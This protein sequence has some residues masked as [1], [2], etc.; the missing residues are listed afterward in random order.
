MRTSLIPEAY[1][2]FPVKE[3][4][5]LSAMQWS[6]DCDA[7]EEA[8][9]RT[10]CFVEELQE[11]FHGAFAHGSVPHFT[12]LMYLVRAFKFGGSNPAF[13]R[14]KRVY[15]ECSTAA[16]AGRN[17]G[18]L[19][20]HLCSGFA[21]M[22][23]PPSI[24]ELIETL[25]ARRRTGLRQRTDLKIDV[26]LPLSEAGPKLAAQIASLSDEQ[27]RHWF[28]F[29]RPS[30][31]PDERIAE[32]LE[33][34]PLRVLKLIA[35]ARTSPRLVGAASLIPALD[36]GLTIPPRKRSPDAVPQGGYSDVT[37]R[38][39]P[40]RLLPSQFA[41]DPDEFVRRFAEHELLYFQRE[42]P[43]E[44]QKPERVL[45]F[46]QG[47]RTWGRV[48][49]ALAGAVLSL[50][51]FDAR[52]IGDV[53]LHATSQ[54]EPLELRTAKIGALRDVLE[55]SDFTETPEETFRQALEESHSTN[56][57]SPPPAVVAARQ[58]TISPTGG[59]VK[60]SPPRDV[61]VLTHPRNVPSLLEAAESRRPG[62]RIFPFAVEE[63]GSA[64]IGELREEG[65]VW[66]RAFRLDLRAA[67]EARIEEETLPTAARPFIPWIPWTGDVEPIGF[68][69]RPGIVA[70]VDVMGFTAEGDWLVTASKN[71]LLHAIACDGSSVEV[72]PRGFKDGK[73]LPRVRTIQ[74]V[75]NGVVID[76]ASTDGEDEVLSVIHYDMVS[77]TVRFHSMTVGSKSPVC[78]AQ[79][80][81]DCVIVF[82]G[83]SKQPKKAVDLKTGVVSMF[84]VAHSA[85]HIVAA[86]L[87]AKSQGNAPHT[88]SIHHSSESLPAMAG[89]FLFIDRHLIT[90]RG[91]ELP[92]VTF[93]PRTNGKPILEGANIESA[94][95]AGQTLALTLWKEDRKNDKLILFRAPDGR[96]LMEFE[97]TPNSLFVLSPDG[98][99]IARRKSRREVSVHATTE[100]RPTFARA[101]S[102]KLHDQLEI[103]LNANPFQLGITIGG[104]NHA[105]EIHEGR[106]VHKSSTVES[107]NRLPERMLL[108]IPSYDE[109]RFPGK[110]AVSASNFSAILDR[111][112]L[113]HLYGKSVAHGDLVVIVASFCIRRDL[114]AVW[115]PS[116]VF[117]GSAA[118]IGGPPHPNAAELIGAAI[119]NAGGT[120]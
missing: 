108:N 109:Q 75:R 2:T 36:A 68:P 65:L 15:G 1:L 90:V 73:L 56:I 118:L 54:R 101:S 112:G 50:L 8:D 23:N 106:L 45:V 20:A 85:H 26:A 28:R 11:V 78:V 86:A 35:A 111:L 37:T 17:I 62:D 40:D 70:D 16:A 59:E 102:A 57:N 12:H 49:L 4:I 41:L 81:H 104:Q 95:L 7:I 30:L 38:G 91:T 22:L 64:K 43:H 115:I 99:L 105:F 82:E 117:W 120:T 19:I 61:I 10:V 53:R 33:S 94:Q 25:A 48:R 84:S 44:A 80:E 63:D 113:V 69:F 58:S 96:I 77:R 39:D 9:G 42:E 6:R 5:F 47:V 34:L 51:K 97:N 79:A 13:E 107:H 3:E 88:L 32:E 93:F 52:K 74:P 31:A 72:L 67:S 103:H 14:F 89:P 92:W 60:N 114:A 46:D 21:L 100:T 29:G 24:E 55:A 76:A 116:G 66:L 119:M 18:A 87:R 71:G 83:D 98:E 27:L 110:S